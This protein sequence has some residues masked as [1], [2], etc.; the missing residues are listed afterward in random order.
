VWTDIVEE[1]RSESCGDLSARLGRA[2]RLLLLDG[3]APRS[4][5]ARKAR[6]P[7]D[8]SQ[9]GEDAGDAQ[10]LW[11]RRTGNAASSHRPF[12]P[13]EVYGE[14]SCLVGAGGV[15]TPRPAERSR[16]S[17]PKSGVSLHRVRGHWM[18]ASRLSCSLVPGVSVVLVRASCIVILPRLV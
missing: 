8:R 18:P 3:E 17:T 15:V 11:R 13:P 16:L 12:E 1:R 6:E 14:S 7:T 4:P 5:H 9:R 2:A 10:N